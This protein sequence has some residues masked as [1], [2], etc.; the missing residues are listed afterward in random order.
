MTS[1]AQADAFLPDVRGLAFFGFP[2]HPVGKPSA[3]RAFHLDA[4][5]VPMLFLQGARDA[6]A[7]PTFLLPLVDRLGKRA[8][9]WHDRDADHSFH[10]PARSGRH[11]AQ[12]LD[13]AMD[14]FAAW[15]EAAVGRGIS[16]PQQ[17]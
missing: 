4:V 9:L 3:D 16:D 12:V 13:E 5:T 17:I 1:Q 7:D 11:D 14:A 8:T 15:A 2:L 6:L 10:V